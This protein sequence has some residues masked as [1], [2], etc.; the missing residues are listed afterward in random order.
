VRD[1]VSGI[2]VAGHDPAEYARAMERIVTAPALRAE[3]SAGAVQ[4][5]ASFAWDHTAARTI[6]VYRAAAQSMRDDLGAGA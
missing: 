4:Q 2:L 6:E 1:G 5:A 3:L